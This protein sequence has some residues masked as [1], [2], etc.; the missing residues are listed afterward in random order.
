MTRYVDAQFNADRPLRNLKA[1]DRIRLASW[2]SATAE[3]GTIWAAYDKWYATATKSDQNM[4][5]HGF[6]PPPRDTKDEFIARNRRNGGH[7]VWAS[8][9]GTMICNDQSYYAEQRRIHDEAIVVENNDLVSVA[10]K[11][12]RIAVVKGNEGR[13]PNN[14]DPIHF[15]PAL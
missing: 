8:H 10:G 14:S 12:W 3:V 2:T 13:F 1:G 9:Y 6:T 4:V 7:D 11:L 15:I 5:D